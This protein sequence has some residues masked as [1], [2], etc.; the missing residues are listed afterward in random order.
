LK[1]GYSQSQIASEV[2]VSPITVKYWCTGHS[3]L[4]QAESIKRLKKFLST[5]A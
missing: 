1:K 3:L 2:G 5:H 4:A